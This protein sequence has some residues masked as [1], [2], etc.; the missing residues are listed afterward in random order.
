MTKA[1]GPAGASTRLI[2]FPCRAG[3]RSS[4]GGPRAWP[5]L[6]E[7]AGTVFRGGGHTGAKNKM[8]WSAPTIKPIV[9]GVAAGPIFLCELAPDVVN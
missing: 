8:M 6:G 7:E 4:V 3:R 5:P 9:M 2:F 1:G